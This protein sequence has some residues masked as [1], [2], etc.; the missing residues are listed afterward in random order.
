VS[1]FEEGFAEWW[2]EARMK[3]RPPKASAGSW[4]AYARELAALGV[5]KFA[6]LLG[7]ARLKGWQ[8]LDWRYVAKDWERGGSEEVA[9][10]EG[11]PLPSWL[12][13]DPKGSA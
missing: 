12:D 2:E 5:S 9:D 7:R 1:R 10:E 3:G 4:R 13:D 11:G 6:Y 8:A